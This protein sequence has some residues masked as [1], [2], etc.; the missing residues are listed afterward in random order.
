MNLRRKK[1]NVEYRIKKMS[2]SPHKIEKDG[3]TSLNPMK[4]T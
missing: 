2:K 4:L 3:G 1:T